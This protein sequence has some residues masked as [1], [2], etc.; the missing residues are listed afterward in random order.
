M[1]RRHYT[2]F[3]GLTLALLAFAAFAGSAYADELESWD[4][5]ITNASK[6]FEVLKDFN[7]EAVEDKE[8]GLVWE[9]SPGETDGVAGITAADKVNWGGAIFKCIEKAVGGRTG[10][11]LPRF[12]DLASLVDPNATSAPFLPAGH[13]FSNVQ[14]GDYWS[15][16]SRASESTR[17]WLLLFD[18]GDVDSN[19]KTHSGFVWCVRG[20]QAN[21]D[22]Y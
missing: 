10:W 18:I 19:D 3:V 1:E 22:A 15:A 8:T 9:K 11:R 14:S 7:N 6:R 4:K 17:A 16:T 21:P 13:P 12:F 5:K 20:G 2:R